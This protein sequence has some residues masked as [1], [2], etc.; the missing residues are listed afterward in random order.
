MRREALPE[1]G[2]E[3]LRS[4]DSMHEAVLKRSDEM[5]GVPIAIVLALGSTHCLAQNSPSAD[6]CEQVR[7]AIAQY[8]LEAAR[9]HAMANH[10]LSRDDLRTIEQS[11]GI[12]GRAKRAK[13]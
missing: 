2:A 9:K 4:H 6:Q 5:R 3:P 11:C 7:A 10:G 12:G 1:C 13:R 8:G